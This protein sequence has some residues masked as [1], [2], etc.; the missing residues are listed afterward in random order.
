LRPV[1]RIDFWPAAAPH[2]LALPSFGFPENILVEI[3]P[4]PDFETTKELNIE[5]ISEDVYRNNLI[6]VFGGAYPSQYIRITVDG[7]RTYKGERV[8]GLGEILVS[9]N[10]KVWSVGSKV[11]AQGIPEEY[12]DQLPRLVDGYSRQRRILPQGE[13]VRGLA[14]RRPLDRRLAVVERELEL[15]RTSWRTTQFRISI[16]GGSAVF[17]GLI[18]GMVLQRL[19][20]RRILD[21]LKRRITRDLHDD[22]G[23]N[24]G[25]VALTAEKLKYADVNAEVR[26]AI[27]D[28]S[29]LAREAFALLKSRRMLRITLYR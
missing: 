2:L 11:V 4:D 13:W 20:R 17:A 24:L 28:L 23:S 21:R 18:I 5:N 29:L 8:L 3:S 6:S 10:E 9:S 22:V 12:L 14:Q 19:Q 1:G 26:Q 15:A 16:W 27:N 25:S 7:L